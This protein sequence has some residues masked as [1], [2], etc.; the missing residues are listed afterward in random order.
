MAYPAQPDLEYGWEKL[1]AER[2]YSAYGRQNAYKVRI[3]RFHNIY[4]EQGTWRGGREKAPAALCRKVAHAMLTGKRSIDVWGDG[5]QTRSFCY[6]DDC[7]EGIERLM[8]SD[9]AKPLNVGS[10]ELISI[11][12]LARLIMD[13]AGY[14]VTLEHDLSKPQGV[15]GRSSDN[16]LCQDVL[17][18]QPC[19]SLTTGLAQTYKWIEQQVAESL[20]RRELA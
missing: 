1:M 14:T 16:S 8:D 17:G 3:A 9:Y 13:I 12:E 19:I 10:A 4:G 20:I 18:W 2:I 6:I 15:R 7:L 5:E 11:N